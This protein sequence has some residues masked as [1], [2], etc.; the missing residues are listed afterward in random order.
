M[1]ALVRE[2]PP[3]LAHP[4]FIKWAARLLT[5]LLS[6]CALLFLFRRLGGA[7][8][9]PLPGI[10]LVTVAAMGIA[11]TAAIRAL[12][13]S[14]DHAQH[15]LAQL[16]LAQHTLATLPHAHPSREASAV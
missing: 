7:L 12:R 10:V 14:L 15:N 3:Q 4:T 9:S 13:R 5:A 8:Q 1:E 2:N 16:N 11:L 6:C